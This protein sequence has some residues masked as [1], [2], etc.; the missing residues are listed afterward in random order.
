MYCLWISHKNSYQDHSNDNEVWKCPRNMA[1]CIKPK[2]KARIS[3]LD[4]TNHFQKLK[5]FVRLINDDDEIVF[6]GKQK[7]QAEPTPAPNGPRTSAPARTDPTGSPW[8]RST[9]RRRTWA[10]SWRS[11]RQGRRSTSTR[12]CCTGR[13]SSQT[14]RTRKLK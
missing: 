8:Y 10:R 14:S 5:E 2:K 3:D 12:C 6:S 9:R 11:A 4:F 7:Y 1:S 13:E